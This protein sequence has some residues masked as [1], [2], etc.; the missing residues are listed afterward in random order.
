M[1]AGASHSAL[2]LQAACLDFSSAPFTRHCLAV[3]PRAK[4]TYQ[5]A[6]HTAVPK[7]SRA[8]QHTPVSSFHALPVLALDTVA[9]QIADQLRTHPATAQK[10]G[11]DSSSPG[12]VQDVQK[13][14][15]GNSTHQQS[16]PKQSE[17]HAESH[18]TQQLCHR[19]SPSASGRHQL[20]VQAIPRAPSQARGAARAARLHASQAG[21]R[22]L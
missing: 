10:V 2:A 13:A 17:L 7:W 6:K 22:R 3:V 18:S 12:L 19:C 11:V 1:I 20:R 5:Q 4:F 9:S 21:G 16:H 15:R 14:A 8:L